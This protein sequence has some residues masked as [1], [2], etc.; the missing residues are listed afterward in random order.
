W[1]ADGSYFVFPAHRAPTRLSTLWGDL[2][3]TLEK[4]RPFRKKNSNPVQLTYGPTEFSVPVRGRD[5]KRMF[6]VGTQRRG[7]L[8]RYDRATRQFVPFL[9]GISADW[10]EFSRDG[11][12]VTY[13]S[14]PEMNLWRSRAD[15]G[16]RLQLTFSPMAVMA[17]RWSPD[18]MHIAFM[19]YVSNE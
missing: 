3:A 19:G 18:G 10:V 13:V 14:F 11:K 4:G 2:W 16:E 1:T 5:A 15:G 7:E 9:S 6:A 17:P 12:W 8:V